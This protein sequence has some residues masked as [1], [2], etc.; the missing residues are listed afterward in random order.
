[1][2]DLLVAIASLVVLVGGMFLFAASF[3]LIEDLWDA[4]VRAV[5][6]RL[7]AAPPPTPAP[8]TP[9][10]AE[11]VPDPDDDHPPRGAEPVPDP[12]DDHPPRGR[13][14]RADYF[15]STEG[16]PP[17]FAKINFDFGDAHDD[18][19]RPYEKPSDDR[20]APGRDE[21]D[22]GAEGEDPPPR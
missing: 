16:M 9:R 8:E 11:P 13:G 1:M 15:I 12:D 7:P 20:T 18:Y 14:A 19:G 10:G 17:G 6:N 3:G 22:G 4:I 5:T 21:R 2:K